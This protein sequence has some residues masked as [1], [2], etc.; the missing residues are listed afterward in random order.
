MRNYLSHIIYVSKKI[1]IWWRKGW[2]SEGAKD[3]A[4]ANSDVIFEIK[5]E[6]ENFGKSVQI[7]THTAY[8]MYACYLAFSRLCFWMTWNLQ[9]NNTVIYTRGIVRI[10]TSDMLWLAWIWQMTVGKLWIWMMM[11]ACSCIMMHAEGCYW[12]K[13]HNLQKNCNIKSN[14]VNN[15][16]SLW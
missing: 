2:G 5:L 14:N 12:T 6:F 15:V 1:Q 16:F 7:H 4:G 13:W 8:C 11:H 3:G 10:P 9:W